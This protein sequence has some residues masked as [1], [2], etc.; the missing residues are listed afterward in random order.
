MKYKKAPIYSGYLLTFCIS[1]PSLHNLN[2]TSVV[3]PTAVS[4]NSTTSSLTNRLPT[5]DVVVG[6]VDMETTALDGLVGFGCC[7][8]LEGS[9]TLNQ[10]KIIKQMKKTDK[11][12][13]SHNKLTF[14]VFSS[15][16]LLAKN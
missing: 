16:V 12:T 5:R 4:G 10:I 9:E 3:L 7:C 15:Q 11:A 1:L 2:F 8:C 13:Q 14:Y 6:F